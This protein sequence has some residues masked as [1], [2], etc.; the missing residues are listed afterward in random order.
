MPTLSIVTHKNVS[1][2]PVILFS[3]SSQDWAAPCPSSGMGGALKQYLKPSPCNWWCFPLPGCAGAEPRCLHMWMLVD[4]TLQ[5][6]ERSSLTEQRM[7]ELEEIPAPFCSLAVST[8]KRVLEG[9]ARV[10]N[11]IRPSRKP[12]LNE[13]RLSELQPP[14]LPTLSS[15][16]TPMKTIVKAQVAPLYFFQE[17][18]WWMFKWHH[19]PFETSSGRPALSPPL[20]L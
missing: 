17:V 19:F 12:E 15:P 14:L 11:R 1:P 5:M 8:H 2:M 16:L 7:L 6:D 4:P 20:A 10:P 3:Y 9:L 18:V 13:K